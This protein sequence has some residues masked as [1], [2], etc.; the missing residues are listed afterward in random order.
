VKSALGPA[1]DVEVFPHAAD[2]N[3]MVYEPRLLQGVDYFATSSAVRGRFEADTAR[4]AVEQP[5]LRA[6][7]FG[8]RRSPFA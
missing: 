2:F 7:R 6:A 8:R 5:V 3:R 1:V 4:Y